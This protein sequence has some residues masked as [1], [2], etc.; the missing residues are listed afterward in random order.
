[1]QKKSQKKLKKIPKKSQNLPN[2]SPNSL[3]FRKFPIFFSNLQELDGFV[4]QLGADVAQRVPVEF[5][6]QVPLDFLLLQ[7]PEFAHGAGKLDPGD[8]G[9]MG[10]FPKNPKNSSKF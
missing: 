7:T 3:N 9:K 2:F 6:L 8:H 5:A 1:M 4:G 10:K